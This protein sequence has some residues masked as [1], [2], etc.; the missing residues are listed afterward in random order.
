MTKEQF[1]QLD[2]N[3]FAQLKKLLKSASERILYLSIPLLMLGVTNLRASAKEAKLFF[4]VLLVLLFLYN[5]PP[6][7]KIMHMFEKKGINYKE[8][9]AK[10]FK[11]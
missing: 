9:K 1:P 3:E 11:F 4:L 10:G 5:I 6:R 2:E 8:L 7:N